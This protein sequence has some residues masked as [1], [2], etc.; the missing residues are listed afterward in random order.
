[1]EVQMEVIVTG[2]KRYSFDG[3]SGANIYTLGDMVVEDDKIGCPTMKLS[4]EHGVLDSFKGSTMPTKFR[5][6]CEVRQGAKDTMKYH[7]VGASP[8][9]SEQKR[10][11]SDKA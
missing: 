7:V 1:M 8:I 2:V 4:G 10:P 3:N 6:N 9:L 5:L 11:V